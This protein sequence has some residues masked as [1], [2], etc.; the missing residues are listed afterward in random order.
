MAV[1][2]ILIHKKAAEL[3]YKRKIYSRILSE[4]RRQRITDGCKSVTFWTGKEGKGL[5][6]RVPAAKKEDTCYR[7]S[8]FSNLFTLL[9]SEQLFYCISCFTIE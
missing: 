4:E 7:V 2:L 1:I 6:K 5:M 9:S 8:S 3:R